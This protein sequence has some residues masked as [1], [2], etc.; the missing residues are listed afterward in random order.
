MIYG[1]I[2]STFELLTEETAIK[3]KLPY[4]TLDKNASTAATTGTTSS[5]K[6]ALAGSVIAMTTGNMGFAV[7]GSTPVLRGILFD[8]YCSDLDDSQGSGFLTGIISP[9][10]GRTSQCLIGGTVTTG[11][12]LYVTAVNTAGASKLIDS[13][14]GTPV[15][16]PVAYA[17]SYDGT[18]LTYYWFGG[19][20]A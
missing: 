7:S 17:I 12:P 6:P 16:N 10:V 1:K 11:I 8:T 18:Y 5:A 13:T 19:T 20:P 3:W 9:H 4:G 15:G 14:G 2:S